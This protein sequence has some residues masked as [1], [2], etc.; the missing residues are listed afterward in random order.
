M[1]CITIAKASWR[2]AKKHPAVRDE[3]S[4]SKT[5]KKDTHTHKKKKR[6]K[7]NEEEAGKDEEEEEG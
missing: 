7:E 2:I 5:N 6:K 3:L 4:N 1:H